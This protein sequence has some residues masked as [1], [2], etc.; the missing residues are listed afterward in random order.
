MKSL[1]ERTRLVKN[2]EFSS[3]GDDS[4]D[5][6]NTFDRHSVYGGPV[7]SATIRD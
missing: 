5:T 7:T 1:I 4:N 6:N 3:L 2:A